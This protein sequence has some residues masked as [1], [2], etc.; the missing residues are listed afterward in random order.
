MV[1]SL[2]QKGEPAAQFSLK[3]FLAGGKNSIAIL[4]PT[5][6][7]KSNLAMA[8][9]QKIGGELISCD[10]VQIYKDFNIG[11]A[12]PSLEE[13]KLVPH[14]LIDLVK[15]HETFDAA[16][17]RTLAL[18]AIHNIESRG[19]IP[20]IVGGTGLYFRALC[21]EKFHALPHDKD[22]RQE[23]ETWTTE[24]LYQKLTK[25]DPQRAKA[26]HPND[27][28]RITRA[29]E[30]ASISG[31][32]MAELTASQEAHETFRPSLI[33]LCKP[34]RKILEDM[35]RLR[36]TKMLKNGLIAEVKNL[37]TKETC[38]V[39][40][41]P[42]QSIGYKQ[43][44]DFLM[45][46]TTEEKLVESIVIASRQYARKQLMWFRKNSVDLTLENPYEVAASLDVITKILS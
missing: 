11:S 35:L 43:V 27:R 23:L 21:G 28:F 19:K 16:Q 3:P 22:L 42:M 40:A 30:L 10:S 25:L 14:H 31:L 8:L 18:E 26:L 4:G 9:A 37:L 12:K 38:P 45:G 36:T 2:I 24:A 29:C 7:G 17:Y 1:R 15:W 5:A 13:Q 41:K 39:E 20:I 44:C 6:S 46:S 33:V 34:P 32:T